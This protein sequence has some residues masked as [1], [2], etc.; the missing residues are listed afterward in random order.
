VG[1]YAGVHAASV[2]RVSG[3]AAV[4]DRGYASF[5]WCHELTVRLRKVLPV[6][7]DLLRKIVMPRS[8]SIGWAYE[9]RKDG[10]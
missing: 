9:E 2:A 4:C 6:L 8:P 5:L 10:V 1:G 7:R 3:P